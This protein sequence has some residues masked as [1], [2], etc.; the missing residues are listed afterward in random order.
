[1]VGR[2]KP[3]TRETTGIPPRPN[4]WAS[5]GSDQVLLS[6]IEVRKQQAVFPLKFFC[7][8]HASSI[9]Q[10][11]LCVTINVLRALTTWPFILTGWSPIGLTTGSTPF[12][13]Y[14]K[15]DNF[16]LAYYAGG[17]A[18]PKRPP[19]EGQARDRARARSISGHRPA[20]TKS[21]EARRRISPGTPR[22]RCSPALSA[23]RSRSEATTG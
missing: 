18:T 9:A 15:A 22:G 14:E 5:N 3:V 10:R 1:M 6:L 2:E 7:C 20:L 17:E 4:C 23:A 12:L 11:A 8:A 13:G 19:F 16:I 21:S